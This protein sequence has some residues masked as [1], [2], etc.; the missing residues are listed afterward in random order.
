MGKCRKGE[1]RMCQSNEIKEFFRDFEKSRKKV[2]NN[3]KKTH[4]LMSS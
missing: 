1:K 2:L 3:R 4:A